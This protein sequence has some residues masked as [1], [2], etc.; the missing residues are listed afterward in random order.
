MQ[1]YDRLRHRHTIRYDDGDVELVPLWAPNQMVSA[2][3]TWIIVW[4]LCYAMALLSLVPKQQMH[5]VIVTAFFTTLI[6]RH[7]LAACSLLT[8]CQANQP[9]AVPC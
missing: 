2:L 4:G 6:S 9:A 8:H 1:D 5:G 7:A 3:Q